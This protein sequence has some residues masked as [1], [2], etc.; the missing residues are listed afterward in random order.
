M[1]WLIYGSNQFILFILRYVICGCSSKKSRIPSLSPISSQMA[2][3]MDRSLCW[4]FNRS[5]PTLKLLEWK[6]QSY[7]ACSDRKD[8][9]PQWSWRAE[10][11]TEQNSRKKDFVSSSNTVDLCYSTDFTFLKIS[12]ST[13]YVF[14]FENY[15][16]RILLIKYLA[17]FLTPHM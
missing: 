10:L 14:V 6:K 11:W 8:S 4:S 17:G 5:S 9:V 13:L 3:K 7:S 1:F 12:N 15:T 16:S 2:Q